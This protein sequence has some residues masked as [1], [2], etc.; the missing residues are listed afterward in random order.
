MLNGQY[1]H[2]LL[3]GL[4][5]VPIFP[6]PHREKEGKCW[7]TPNPGLTFY[8][9]FLFK[10]QKKNRKKVE[11]PNERL[12]ARTGHRT[13]PATRFSS[14][15][16]H[17]LCVPGNRPGGQWCTNTAQ[18]STDQPTHVPGEPRPA[19]GRLATPAVLAAQGSGGPAYAG[20]TAAPPQAKALPTG[21]ASPRRS[22]AGAA[23]RDSRF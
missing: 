5:K 18:W 21:C 19:P 1:Y 6:S 10:D 2:L 3:Q 16:A 12:P 11:L 15:V 14:L 4:S 13:N 20:A 23:P 7:D 9:N 22:G 8:H 17:H